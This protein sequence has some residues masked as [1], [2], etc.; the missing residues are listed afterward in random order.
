[1]E[2]I[3]IIKPINIKISSPLLPML[4]VFLI[5]D[6]F[7]AVGWVWGVAGTFFAAYWILWLIGIFSVYELVDVIKEIEELK[8]KVK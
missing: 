7:N 1:M 5:L 6:R 8:E 3:K 2:K 4:V